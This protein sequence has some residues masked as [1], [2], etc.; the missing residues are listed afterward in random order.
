ML[1][2]MD[3]LGHISQGL[4][5]LIRAL[6]QYPDFTFIRLK[7]TQNQPEQGGFTPAVGAD[8][9]HEIILPDGQID[10]GKD[11]LSIVEKIHIFNRDQGFF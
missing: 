1:I 11:S 8:N 6:P 7:K 2:D 10:I 5:Q 9:G 4:G 3:I